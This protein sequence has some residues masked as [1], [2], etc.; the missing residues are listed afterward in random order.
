MRRRGTETW[1]N[2]KCLAVD[3]GLSRQLVDHRLPVRTCTASAFCNLLLLSPYSSLVCVALCQ[4]CACNSGVDF[5]STILPD[6]VRAV[7]HGLIR[8]NFFLSFLNE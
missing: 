3:R 1:R 7:R 5:S 6:E 4:L 2:Q 8:L